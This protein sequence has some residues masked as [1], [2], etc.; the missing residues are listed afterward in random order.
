[1]SLLGSLFGGGASLAGSM[2]SA[3]AMRKEAK[4]NRDWQE[5]MSNTTYQRTMTDMAAAGL[6]PILAYKQGGNPVGGGATAAVPN[7]GDSIANGLTSGVKAGQSGPQIALMKAQKD[8]ATAREAASNKDALLKGQKISESRAAEGLL[9]GQQDATAANAN[10]AL[11]ETRL[12]QAQIP[13]AETLAEFDRSETGKALNVGSA[14]GQRI[15]EG[16]APILDA[17]FGKGKKGRR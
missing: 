16:V 2:I 11:A 12:L 17:L 15:G 13:R 9:Y 6:N 1:M 10:K 4:R 8:E 3:K 7:F 14:G 5:R